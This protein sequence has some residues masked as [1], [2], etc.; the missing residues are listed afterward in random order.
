MRAEVLCWEKSVQGGA[1]GCV[2]RSPGEAGGKPQL[3]IVVC[4]SLLRHDTFLVA[5]VRLAWV[6]Q[7]Q[8]ELRSYEV[9][10]F[11]PALHAGFHESAWE[12]DPRPGSTE[13][14][15]EQISSQ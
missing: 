2:S 3:E 10:P 12:T 7:P 9:Q 11:S 14:T 5:S 8:A 13:V 1:E 4:C 6:L 15:W